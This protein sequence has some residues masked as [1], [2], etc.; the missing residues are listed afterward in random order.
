VSPVLLVHHMARRHHD[1]PPGSLPA[2][3]ACLEAGA[4]WYIDAT[5]LARALDDGFD[6]IA[7]LHARGAGV[8]ART[9]DADRPERFALARRLVEARVDRITTNDAP[10]LA[11]V[12]DA[13]VTY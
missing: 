5:L 2:V 6:W 7:G 4:T 3:R 10:A 8:D 1:H 9:L 12:L 11:R 13:D